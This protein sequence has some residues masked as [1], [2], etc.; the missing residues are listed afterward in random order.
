VTAA[1]AATSPQ[2]EK[3]ARRTRAR[4]PKSDDGQETVSA[5]TEEKPARRTRARKAPTDEPAGSAASTDEKPAP[6]SRARKAATEEAGG[7]TKSNQSSQ[8]N[9][10]KP[11]RA[12]VRKP[13]ADAATPA[14]GDAQPDGEPQGIWGRFRSARK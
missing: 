14:S 1:D 13:K 8:E 10:A 3:P 11:K 2:D 7:T 5:A 4:K 6:R 9:E 12:R